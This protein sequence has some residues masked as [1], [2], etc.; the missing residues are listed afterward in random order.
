MN[1]SEDILYEY[2]LCSELGLLVGMTLLGA[3]RSGVIE[4]FEESRKYGRALIVPDEEM[5]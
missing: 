4:W 1:I 3:T 2:V 5:D